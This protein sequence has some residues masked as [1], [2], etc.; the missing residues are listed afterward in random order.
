M[1]GIE[2]IPDMS[3]FT[4]EGGGQLLELSG[5]F[6]QGVG[7]TIATIG[8]YVGSGAHVSD[9]IDFNAMR[10]GIGGGMVV[11][12]VAAALGGELLVKAGHELK[13]V[14]YDNGILIEDDSRQ[15]ESKN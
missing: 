13:Y 10:H 8:S 15:E 4:P 11:F 1:T 3:G 12:G 2:A 7:L 14:G 9:H 6:I 5:A